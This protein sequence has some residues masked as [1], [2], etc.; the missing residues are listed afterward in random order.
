MLVRDRGNPLD[1]EHVAGRVADRLAV[2]D[3]GVVTHRGLPRVEVVGIDP[4]QLD[5]HLAQQVF[6]LIHRPAVE[7]RGR[8]HVVARLEER[9]QCRGLRCD[10][11][12]ER[13]RPTA[14]FEV[15][16]A[17]LEHRDCGIHDARVGVPVL[18]QVE[19]RGRR[20]RVLEHVAG[21]LVD[22]H[23]ARA[24]VGVRPLSGVHLAR[25]EPERAGLFGAASIFHRA[26]S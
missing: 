4:R 7:R 19:V 5:V 6:E 8:D 25:V 24:G 17:F 18:L 11:A 23:R 15:R 26:N 12:C 3:L 10:A 22:R 1:V 14:P 9:E 21:R 20:F 2:E 13:H 16:H